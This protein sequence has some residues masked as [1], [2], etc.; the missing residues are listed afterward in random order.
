VSSISS[1][2][3]SSASPN[4]API[5]VVPAISDDGGPDPR[6]YKYFWKTGEEDEKRNQMLALAANEVRLYA[7]QLAKNHI[8]ET[9]VTP[10]AAANRRTAAKESKP[11][12]DNVQF[13]G[14][15]IWLNN[16]LVMLLTADA[17]IPG[18]SQPG[19]NAQPYHVTLVARTD[20]YG[21]LKKI[22]SGITDRFHL[23]VTPQL[24]FIDVVDADG[25][26]RGEMLFRETSDA[27]SGYIIY[28]ATPDKLWKLF[29]S[30]SAE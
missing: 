6:S 22:H 5:R 11:V 1:G 26:G 20:I 17:S 13:R 30:L 24:E 25:D 21:D 12:F 19:A 9:P 4:A 2:A 10:K 16:Q 15:D 14:Y 3:A 27:G 29:D 7:L 18:W 8:S 23:D 28:R